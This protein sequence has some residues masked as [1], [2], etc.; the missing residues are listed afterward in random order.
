M[1]ALVLGLCLIKLELIESL[2]S[3]LIGILL[4]LLAFLRMSIKAKL[5]IEKILKKN[6]AFYHLIMGVVHGATNLGG[7]FLSILVSVYFKE[8]KEILYVIAFYY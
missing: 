2:L 8:K 6:I 4:L 3:L 1:H 7:A 5:L